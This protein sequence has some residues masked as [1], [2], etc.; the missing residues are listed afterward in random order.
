M[1][2]EPADVSKI[3]KMRRAPVSRNI[4]SSQSSSIEQL[5]LA[6]EEV[7]WFLITLSHKQYNN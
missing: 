4:I 7:V 2:E 1:L 3:F 6:V 5:A